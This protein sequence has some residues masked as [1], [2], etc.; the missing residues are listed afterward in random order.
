MPA[1]AHKNYYSVLGV[2]SSAS[3]EEIRKAYRRLARK[4]HP[5]V[6][7]NNK[8]AEDRFKE[9]QEAYDILSDPKKREFFDRAGFFN[10]QAFQQGAEAFAGGGAG[11]PA[12]AGSGP[13]FDFSGFDFDLGG[14]AGGRR[15]G[16][17]FRDLFGNLFQ[18]GRTEAE[19]ETGG[20]LE[21][22]ATIGFWDAVK[23]TVLRLQVPRQ[24]MCPQCKGSGAGGP[25]GTCPECGGKGQISQKIGDMRFNRKCPACGGS[26]K[27]GARCPRCHGEG[28][29][30]REETI[31][32]RIRPGTRE[33][34]RLRLAGKGNWGPRGYGDLY[35][36]LRIQPHPLFRREGDDITL[37]APITVAE[38]ALGAKI[39]VPTIDGAALVKIPPGTQSGQRF[40]LRE[41][42]VPS[43]VREG[44]RGDQY[45]EVQVV[46]PRLTDE[47]SKELL[48]EFAQLNAA[49]VRAELPRLAARR[50]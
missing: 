35:V 46:V 9:V 5:D 15:G 40:R 45:V 26:G 21:Y 27:L 41:R 48:R 31:E 47:R 24:D 34:A 19:P 37:Q 42:G 39:E 49:D 7:P 3:A 43:A 20:D 36:V 50:E 6:N 10:E 13:G 29:L 28:R 18:R 38:A 32:V 2:K 1:A 22:A 11:E 33:G 23:G 14:E 8:S 30:A 25:G 44:A 17:S 12:G 4:Y 16:G